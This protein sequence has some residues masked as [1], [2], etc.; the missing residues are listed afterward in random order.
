MSKQEVPTIE[1]STKPDEPVKKPKTIRKKKNAVNSSS[2]DSTHEKSKTPPPAKE[3]KRAAPYPKSTQ[4]LWKLHKPNYILTLKLC[5]DCN[6]A[7]FESKK[8]FFRSDNRL[9]MTVRF[10]DECVAMNMV[11]ENPGIAGI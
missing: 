10:C 4:T 2:E 7:M 3:K 1:D 9:H 5:T 11:S 8:K 6:D